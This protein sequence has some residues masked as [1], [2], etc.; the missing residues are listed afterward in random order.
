MNNATKRIFTEALVII[1]ALIIAMP[2]IVILLSWFM[3]ID[4]IWYHFQQTI[5]SQL[6]INTIILIIG[7]SIGVAV[8]GTSLAWLMTMTEF[9]G[10]KYLEWALLLPFAVPAYVLAFVYLGIFDYAGSLQVFL[11][12][13][14][15]INGFDIRSSY[16]APIIT[17]ILVFYPYVY[18]VSRAA[19]KRQQQN[20]TASA[21]LLGA[22]AWHVF[23]RISIPLIRP[24]I[25]GGVIVTIMET[26][27]D[28]GVV[29]LFNYNTFTTAIYSAWSDFRSIAVATQ[30]A[31]IL[32]FITFTLIYL[33]RLSRGKIKYYAAQVSS[34][35]PY[36]LKNYKSFL[37]FSFVMLVLT[38]SFIIPVVQLVVWALDASNVHYAKYIQLI[39]NTILLSVIATTIIMIVASF[40]AF[41]N[42]FLQKRYIQ[43]LINISTLGYAI[44]GSIMAIGLLYGV[45]HISNISTYL[46]GI[47]FSQYLFGSIF[48]LIL[49][50]SS[51]FM[52]IAYNTMSAAAQQIM[53]SITQSAQLLGS[54]KLRTAFTIQLPMLAPSILAG[55]LLVIV[56]VMKELPA[57]YILKPF[58]W[59]T[60]AI[61]I[62]ELSSEGLNELAA[63]PALIILAITSMLILILQ[64][65]EK[66]NQ[67]E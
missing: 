11:R 45:Y 23:W 4:Q 63:I 38:L 18:I 49:A 47:S 28:F 53:P 64:K 35:R 50:Y 1:L 44:P 5:L 30:L 25:A 29:S 31:T 3:P 43:L 58:N 24:A 12:Q 13:T 66:H 62:Y 55:S 48:L 56:D 2:V 7:V 42:V 16:L 54:G 51:K 57:T 9:F 19:L 8:L 20:I 34:H 61:A 14:F 17:F 40:L 59:D 32:V 39:K 6:F 46:F 15:N 22:S 37:T 67:V 41:P 52:A 36:K 60:L 33:E 26:L 21:Q 65:L 10:R 27:A